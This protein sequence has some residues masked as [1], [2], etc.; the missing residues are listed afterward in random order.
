MI[1]HDYEIVNSEFSGGY[2]RSQNV[3]EESGITLRLEEAMPRGCSRCDEEGAVGA[4]NVAWLGVS[5]GSRH[6]R[7]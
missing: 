5:C 1:G 4:S 6:C 2:V 3:D 7:G